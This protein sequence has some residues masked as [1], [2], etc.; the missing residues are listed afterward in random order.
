MTCNE[1]RTNKQMFVSEQKK[2]KDI[3]PHPCKSRC[4][5]FF[6]CRNAD[7]D[8]RR[9]KRHW[10][11]FHIFFSFFLHSSCFLLCPGRSKDKNGKGER[12]AC[13]IWTTTDAL[14]TGRMERS[15][16]RLMRRRKRDSG[17]IKPKVGCL[18]LFP[19]HSHFEL[20]PI[21]KRDTKELRLTSIPK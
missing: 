16:I 21:T 1:E 4:H 18:L 9:R 2:K 5:A 13:F 3:F 11:R 12:N 8:K 17:Q 14:I 6:E 19:S 7:D 20:E 10:P 15:R